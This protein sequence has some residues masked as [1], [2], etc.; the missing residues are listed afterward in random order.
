MIW[1]LWFLVVYIIV[2]VLTGAWCVKER[3]P[4]YLVLG[5][6]WPAWWVLILAQ[7]FL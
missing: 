2:A 5:A 7:A 1:F 4:G 3:I 6:F